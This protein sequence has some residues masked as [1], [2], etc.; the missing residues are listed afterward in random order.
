MILALVSSGRSLSDASRPTKLLSPESLPV[1]TGS[2]AAVPPSRDAL[3]N[4]VP[5]TVMT[6]FESFDFTVAIALPA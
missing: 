5:R 3:S 6:F 2:I 1:S 4:A